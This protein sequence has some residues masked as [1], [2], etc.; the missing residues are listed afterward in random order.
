MAY[1]TKFGMPFLLTESPMYLIPKLPETPTAAEW[2]KLGVNYYNSIYTDDGL[3]QEEYE[4]LKKRWEW[5]Q[6]HMPEELRTGI[7]VISEGGAWLGETIY[8]VDGRLQHNLHI[9][10]VN[11]K[12]CKLI[13]RVDADNKNKTFCVDCNKFRKMTLDR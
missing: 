8:L 2:T 6:S 3:G 9:E 11:C 13:W 1:Q 4:K 5:L 7:H 12:K 10:C